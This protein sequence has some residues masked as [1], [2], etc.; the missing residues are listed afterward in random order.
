MQTIQKLYRIF[1]DYFSTKKATSKTDHQEEYIGSLAFYITKN[2]DID[3]SCFSPDLSNLS[4]DDI[5][6]LSETY[7]EF[8]S[9]IN[10]GYLKDD[11]LDILAKKYKNNNLTESQQAKYK[12]FFD[13]VVFHWAMIY[14][15]NLKK[16]KQ[17]SKNDQP[18]IRPS[19]VF[20]SN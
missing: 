18:L 13:N 9:Y 3:I 15:E 16:K 1:L 14:S 17:V 11:I 7:A 19:S 5:N 8:L 6:Y 20:H 12:L 2:K 10:D 4:L